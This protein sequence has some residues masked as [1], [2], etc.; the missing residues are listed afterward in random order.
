MR[1]K[2]INQIESYILENESV[3][4]DQICEKFGISKNTAHRDLNAL[5]ERNTV[6]K[7]YGGATAIKNGPSSGDQLQ[8]F[9]ERNVSNAAGKQR[10]AEAAA[11]FVQENDTIYI[12][13]G[14][15]A[16]RI[17]D[18]IMKELNN[19]TIITNS[20][21]ILYKSLSYP[22]LSV[23]A[24]PGK[25]KCRTASLVGF[26]SCQLLKAYNISK[27]FMA[28]TALSLNNGATTGTYEE[29]EIKKIVN[30]RSITKYLLADS[31]KFDK[32]SLVTYA[33]LEDF[34]YIVTDKPLPQEYTA[35][36]EKNH[37]KVITAE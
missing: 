25:V 19:V 36:A 34:D 12:D 24:I 2:R 14:T 1:I 9:E 17:I 7:V 37:I 20:I 30:E 33:N 31:S 4:L 27:A 8:T 21:P 16:G 32:T 6:Q 26:E 35:F 22:K 5:V 18:N 28:C 10:I 13:S 29:C 3:T 11:R 23:I 15:T